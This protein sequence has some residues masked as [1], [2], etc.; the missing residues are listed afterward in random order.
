MF[1]AGADSAFDVN[2]VVLDVPTTELPAVFFKD[3]SACFAIRE[4]VAGLADRGV[5]IGD[6]SLS[7]LFAGV[8]SVQCASPAL[9]L[10]RQREQRARFFVQIWFETA[11]L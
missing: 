2:A 11:I 9:V 1:T 3:A 4:D 10:C 5:E 6:A 8:F 7:A